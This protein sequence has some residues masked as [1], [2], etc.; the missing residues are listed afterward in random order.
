MPQSN[1]NPP[2]SLAWKAGIV[3]LYCFGS[4][5]A[6]GIMAGPVLLVHFK[7]IGI[8][9]AFFVLF[10]ALFPL[11]AYRAK[12]Y[13]QCLSSNDESIRASASS[14]S[15]VE[16][17]VVLCSLTLW[18]LQT[19]PT[20]QAISLPVGFAIWCG[21]Q[22]ICPILLY[23]LSYARPDSFITQYISQVLM[24][25]CLAVPVPNPI[26]LAFLYG[27]I[28]HADQDSHYANHFFSRALLNNPASTT[29]ACNF[30]KGQAQTRRLQTP[31]RNH[32]EAIP[33]GSYPL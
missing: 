4:L 8:S 5:L 14:E 26:A 18:V 19:S 29:I 6:L 13:L 9:N 27:D 11:S 25:F 32:Y 22:I 21:I 10:F 1:D 31:S 16:N 30:L 28:K 3:L 24:G 23:P 15:V 17:Y 7:V 33:S 2:V 12:K 20:F